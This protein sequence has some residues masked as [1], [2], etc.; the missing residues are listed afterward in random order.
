MDRRAV[1]CVDGRMRTLAFALVLGLS[2]RATAEKAP[3]PTVTRAV[4]LDDNKPAT[5][6]GVMHVWTILH[7][8]ASADPKAPRGTKVDAKRLPVAVPCTE[9]ARPMYSKTAGNAGVLAKGKTYVLTLDTP[10]GDA[11]WGGAYAWEAT[12]IDD[13]P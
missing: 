6:C 11:K 2:P 4:L 7:F 5:V 3:P 13:A 8:D 9:M 1:S 12:K 10:R